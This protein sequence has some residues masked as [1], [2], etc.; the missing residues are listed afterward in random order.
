[1]V[2]TLY[3]LVL[4]GAG[5]QNSHVVRELVQGN[6]KVRI[7]SRNVQKEEPRLLST[8]PGVEVVQGD[9]YDEGVLVSALQDIDAVF[10]NTNGF[11][12][13]EKSEIYWGIRIYELAYWAG[14][15]HFIYSGLPHVSKKSSFNPKYRVPF[16]DGKA[17]VV[18]Y[19]KS[20]PTDKMNWSILESGPYVENFL[21]NHLVPKL[22]EKT[23]EYVFRAFLG[24][25][26]SMALVS[27]VELGWFARY[28]FEHP[29][30]FVG[31]LLSV[32]I[33]HVTGQMMA[34]AFVTV[35]GQKARYEPLTKQELESSFTTVKMGTGHS[36]GYDDPT[37]VTWRQ[38][39]V[40]WWTIWHESHGNTGLWTKDYERL[41]KIKPD[42]MKNIEEWMRSVDYKAGMKARIVLKSDSN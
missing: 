22:D 14:V 24:D 2:S 10:V 30:E 27:L 21:L 29:E 38:M 5:V 12:T 13:G 19:L 20:Q 8:L 6:H 42:R 11:A 39:F 9:T 15:K 3:I 16:V 26:G 25:K 18:E 23:G 37:L 31:D 7:L 4:G 1:M 33:Q 36:P 35:T 32:G 41:D 28:M 40:P 34:D 17:K